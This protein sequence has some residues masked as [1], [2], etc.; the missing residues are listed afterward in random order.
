MVNENDFNSSVGSIE[1]NFL[2]EVQHDNQEIRGLIE[3]LFSA[4][5]ATQKSVLNGRQVIAIG[6][7]MAFAEFYT[8]PELK[9]LCQ[10]LMQLKISEKGR[11]RKDLV[12][13]LQS[14]KTQ[15][16]E[17]LAARKQGVKLL[18]R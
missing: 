10:L 7:A 14:R 18:G 5:G 11:G 17:E 13:A 16:D 6:R 9:D 8:I 2:P 1:D 4:E 3:A 12:A 15:D